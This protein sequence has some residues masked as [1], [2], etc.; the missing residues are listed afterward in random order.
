MINKFKDQTAIIIIT[1]K[2]QKFLEN[3]VASIDREVASKIYIVIA[4]KDQENPYDRYPKDV[5][6]LLC[7]RNPT[8]VGIAK[9]IGLRAAKND[10]YKYLFLLEDDILIKDNKVFEEYILTAADS[11]LWSAQ[12]SYGLHGGIRGN[13]VAL[14]GTP[15]KRASV[16]YTQKVVDFYL[17][18]FQAFT[19]IHTDCLN[20]GGYYDERFLN[21]AEHLSQ[22]DKFFRRTIGL[23]MFWHADIENSHLYITDQDANHE[24][25]VIRK[26][27]QEFEKNFQY[28]WQLFKDMHGYYPQHAPRVSQE[29]VMKILED[30]E[31]RFSKKDLLNEDNPNTE[32][33][34][35]SSD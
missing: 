26:N 3:L 31:S 30:L 24:S 34:A 18:S 2:R 13:N 27:T 4:G 1:C 35:A 16:K 9:N 10:G 8:V 29:D 25:S 32:D 33:R 17:H 22:H 11:G 28:S 6:I 12:L 7:K 23:P 14:D 19:L 5:E 21:A 15:K 20:D